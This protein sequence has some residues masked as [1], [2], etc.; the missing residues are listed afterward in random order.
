MSSP[1]EQFITAEVE[2]R[3]DRMNKVKYPKRHLNI[4]LEDA[5]KRRRT[6]PNKIGNGHMLVHRGR[7]IG[8]V[9]KGM[10]TLVSYQ[11]R[12]AT[13]SLL[14][15]RKYLRASG[16]PTVPGKVFHASQMHAA[17]SHWKSLG[18]AVTVRPASSGAKSGVTVGITSS[19]GFQTAWE[20]AAEASKPLRTLSQQIQI[21][22]YDPG[23]L[24]RLYVV[25]ESAVAAIVR[26]PLYVV[27]DGRSTV[28][29][30]LEQ[31]RRR[32]E[33][34]K[35]LASRFPTVDR[36]SL[37][38]LDITP[39]MVLTAGRIQPLVTSPASPGGVTVDVLDQLAP[40][41]VELATDAMWAFPGLTATGV[42]IVTPHLHSAEGAAVANVDPAVGFDEF[43]YPT[44]GT[45]RRCGLAVLDHMIR[46]RHA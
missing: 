28:Q 36:D 42:D 24:V 33:E 17:H 12:R 7:L 25:S 8:G 11:S 23:L 6:T 18:G 27:G 16:V 21:E 22:A 46:S 43:L 2:P 13:Q 14:A 3:R 41:L 37:A 44:Y 38:G 32:H 40:D 34:C 15:M 4:L 19:E 29:E 20:Y 9:E 30:L 5:K 35:Y 45:Y 1:I 26:V 31:E 39:D 10:T